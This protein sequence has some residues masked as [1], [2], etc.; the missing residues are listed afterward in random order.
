M[1]LRTP[2]D[3]VSEDLTMERGESHPESVRGAR[4]RQ[5][6]QAPDVRLSKT[7]S[8]IL[9]HGA[10]KLGFV[11]GKDGFLN[12]DEILRHPQCKRYTE[13]DVQRVVETNS[14]QRFTLRTHPETGILQIRAN[15][16]HTVQVE[17][18]ELIS[19]SVD[20][21]NV[22]EEAVHGTYL[23]HWPSIKTRGLRRMSRTHIHLAPGLPA[24][25]GVVSGM[26]SDCDL[27]VFI[28][29]RRAL[30]D[31]IPFYFSTNWVILTPGND[32][33]VLPPEYF[34]KVL[35]LKPTR[36]LLPLE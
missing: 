34:Q 20:A 4:G 14:K 29:I 33:G 15:Q 26:R 24:E 16:G 28:E 5:P 13:Q 25:E 30:N 1:S 35:Q 6:R 9:R 7:L 36:R 3:A 2:D 18:L 22:P 32:E 21:G 31:G 11:M 17:D 23:Q 19:I 27:A 10:A 12:V 8:Y